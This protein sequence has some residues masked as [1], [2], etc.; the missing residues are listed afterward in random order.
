MVFFKNTSIGYFY[1]VYHCGSDQGWSD[2]FWFRT[3]DSF[4]PNW[5]PSVALFG[6]MGN[7]NAQSLPRQFALHEIGRQKFV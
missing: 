1:V 5:S 6:D 4:G 2:L 3:Y 7:A